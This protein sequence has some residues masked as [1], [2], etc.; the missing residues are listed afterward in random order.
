MNAQ[1]MSIIRVYNNLPIGRGQIRFPQVSSFSDRVTQAD[2]LLKLSVGHGSV[3]MRDATVNAATRFGVAKVR[4]HPEFGLVLWD[5]T[6]WITNN[7]LSFVMR[8][9]DRKRALHFSQF[10][11]L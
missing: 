9:A 11:L 7:A 10:A 5:S 6:D 4:N 1:K 3:L 2:H 8:L